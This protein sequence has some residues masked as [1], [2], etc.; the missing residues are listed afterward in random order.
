MKASE[1]I[2]MARDRLEKGWC[3]YT[4]SDSDGHVCAAAALGRAMP[5]GQLAAYIHAR[6]A[7]IRA[8]KE[9]GFGSLIGFNDCPTTTK[10]DVLDLF[11]KVII[12][13]EEK[14]L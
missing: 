6:D 8:A 14:G 2:G 12:S 9:Q 3:Q 7:V 1:L 5:A 11:D 10:Q 13:L 4:F